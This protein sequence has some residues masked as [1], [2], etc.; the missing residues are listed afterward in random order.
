MTGAV[1][2]VTA[3]VFFAAGVARPVGTD[4]MVMLFEQFRVGQ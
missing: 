3:I 4:Q 1:K 2:I